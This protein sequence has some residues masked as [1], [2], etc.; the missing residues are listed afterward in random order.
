MVRGSRTVPP[1]T[2]R[3]EVRAPARLQAEQGLPK[4]LGARTSECMASYWGTHHWSQG[5]AR[6]LPGQAYAGDSWE[7]MAC[8]GVCGLRAA[9]NGIRGVL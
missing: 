3:L 8:P 5:Q 2:P 7:I 9:L 4:L 6:A 1:S